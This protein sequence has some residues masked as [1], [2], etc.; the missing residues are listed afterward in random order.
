[1]CFS[2]LASAYSLS[3]YTLESDITSSSLS[4]SLSVSL[5]LPFCLTSCLSLGLSLFLFHSLV[6]YFI[7]PSPLLLS[8]QVDSDGGVCGE[9]MTHSF[10]ELS[11]H[12]KVMNMFLRL[13]QLQLPGHHSDHQRSATRPLQ[14]KIKSVL[15]WSSLDLWSSLKGQTNVKQSSV[16]FLSHDLCSNTY[17]ISIYLLL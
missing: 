16:V 9:K 5:C 12:H 13:G 6:L 2:D 3:G 15:Y 17:R 4:A 10:A 8:K 11:V 7:S 1:M 14:E